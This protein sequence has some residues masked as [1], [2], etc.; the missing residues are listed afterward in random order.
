MEAKRKAAAQIEEAERE[1][2]MAKAQLLAFDSQPVRSKKQ[3]KEEKKSF[4]SLTE[5]TK[6]PMEQE[7]EQPQQSQAKR[8][9]KKGGKNKNQAETLK[10][11]FF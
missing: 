11:G 2:Q 7:L 5:E 1:V 3:I 9:K 10:V 4:P 8:G 6:S